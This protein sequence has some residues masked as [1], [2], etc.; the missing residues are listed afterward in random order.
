MN[1]GFHSKLQTI[2]GLAFVAMLCLLVSHDAA[3]VEVRQFA[4]GITATIHTP[5]EILAQVK[6]GA[7][8]ETIE[9]QTTNGTVALTATTVSMVPFDLQYVSD[10]LASMRNIGAGVEVNVYILPAYPAET[11]G[12]FAR[13]DDIYLAPGTAFVDE[14]TVA[15]ITT[16]EMGHVLT[17][18]FM[19]GV[20]ARWDAYL[21]LRGLDADLNGPQA[22]HADRARE[23]LAED[24]RFLFGGNQATMSGSIENHN[25]V[26]P[27]QVMGLQELLSGFFAARDTSPL[28]A[29]SSA[30]PNPC[31]PL[32]TIAMAV[33]GGT[34]ADGGEA[35]LR[36]FDTRGALVTK[37]VGGVL[38]NG[39]VAIQWNGTMQNG[40][41]VASG[42][43]LYVMQAGGL[44]ARGSVTLVR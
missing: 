32:T 43:Y 44:T 22:I 18:A 9:L 34:L 12:S 15:Y 11:D 28:L 25:L 17:W 10:A 5:N 6:S 41:G 36:V 21:D 14:S 35:V 20:T 19:D 42:H 3:A 13:R 38:A 33:P 29:A 23:I 24:I 40:T 7:G 2:A 1:K 4:N 16:H 37:I 31:N 8:G 27:N 39:R 26:L 30:F